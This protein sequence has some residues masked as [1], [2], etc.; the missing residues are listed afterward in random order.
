MDAERTKHDLRGQ[1][2]RP[3]RLRLSGTITKDGTERKATYE[4][5]S[6]GVARLRVAPAVSREPTSDTSTIV[7]VSA[8]SEQEATTIIENINKRQRRNGLPTIDVAKAISQATGETFTPTLHLADDFH[9]H[10]F[11]RGM[12]K[13]AMGIAWR[14]FGKAYAK[15]KTAT[16]H[17]KF[18]RTDSAEGRAEIPLHGQVWPA[19]AGDARAA[20]VHHTLAYGDWH[21]IVVHHDQDHKVYMTI[22]LF[23]AFD[24]TV[25]L[26]D[27]GAMI[28]DIVAS[29][30]ATVLLV[31]PGKDA[32]RQFEFTEYR[33]WKAQNPAPPRKPFPKV[34]GS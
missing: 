25:D 6:D 15:G 11:D 16:L 31:E 9:V 17:R 22:V 28:G 18:V 24:A 33:K 10:Q 29:G 12:V 13:I 27:F 5:A 32:P 23:G 21:T 4:I 30:S 1:S 14:L 2:G 3:P 19:T 8:T 26:G 34:N 7:R 20:E